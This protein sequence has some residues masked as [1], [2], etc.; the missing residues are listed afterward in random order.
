[1]SKYTIHLYL[2]LGDVAFDGWSVSR[3]VAI[4]HEPRGE[5][6]AS[7]KFCVQSWAFNTAKSLKY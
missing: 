7:V 2:A 3:K 6:V 4:D 1:M 5:E